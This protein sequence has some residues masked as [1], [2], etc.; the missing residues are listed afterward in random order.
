MKTITDDEDVG[1]GEI[2]ISSPIELEATDLHTGRAEERSPAQQDDNIT[3]AMDGGRRKIE[4][5]YRPDQAPPLASIVS[6]LDDGRYT[7]PVNDNKPSRYHLREMAQRGQLGTNEAE[8]RRHWFD[9]QRLKL[10]LAIATGDLLSESASKDWRELCLPVGIGDDEPESFATDVGLVLSD[11]GDFQDSDVPGECRVVDNA[12]GESDQIRLLH[13]RQL[14][15][16]AEDVLGYDFKV[17]KSVIVDNWTARMIGEDELFMDRATASACGTGTIRSALRN[18]SRFYLNLD[19][20]ELSGQRPLDVW[21]LI[22]KPAK[23]PPA[24]PHAG[25]LPQQASRNTRYLSQ[26]RGPVIGITERIAA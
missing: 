2:S 8:N 11:D 12:E 7:P 16:L 26:A 25:S 21:P 22:G 18:L 3:T 14:V 23:L 20:L 5:K 17:L 1:C 19:R 10:D 9:A 13:R 24:T 4:I 6:A 15:S